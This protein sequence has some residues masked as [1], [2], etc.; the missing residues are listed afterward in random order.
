[1]NGRKGDPGKGTLHTVEREAARVIRK[2]VDAMPPCSVSKFEVPEPHGP[3]KGAV[4]MAW[5]L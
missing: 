2:D 5:G 4:N 3:W 1:M